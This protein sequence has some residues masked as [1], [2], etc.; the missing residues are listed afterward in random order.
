MG[1]IEKNDGKDHGTVFVG[2][3]KKFIDKLRDNI[4]K[5][6]IIAV[7]AVYIFQGFFS[8]SKRDTTVL[9]ILGSIGLSI[10]IGVVIST[11]MNSMGIK[12]GRRSELFEASMK[13]YGEAKS[14]STK[15][16]DKLQAWCEYKN[17]IDLEAKKKDIVL[18]AGLSWKGFKFGYYDE[19]PER[20]SEEQKK[21]LERA[22]SAKIEKLYSSDLLSDSN[23]DKSLFG[24][25]F[26]RFGKSEKD[27]SLI[28]NTSD[29]VYKV[30][31]GIVCGLY[32]LKPIFS[33]QILA[34]MIWNTL[35]ILLWLA[36]GSMKYANAKYFMEYEYRQSH[37][38]Q[39]TE[40]INE[41]FITMENR[42]E[43]IEQF[44]D[45]AEIDKYILEFINEK[46]RVK[47]N[48]EQPA[49]TAGSGDDGNAESEHI[50][51]TEPAV[52]NDG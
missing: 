52:E 16:F 17:S 48:A 29:M 22:K 42:P 19:H 13:A 15:Y 32:M 6:L 38:I 14:K 20:L 37:V 39:K 27:Y 35:Q 36:I 23:K 24:K 26:G 34:N 28:V 9:E 11:S 5:L 2:K 31:I 41:F 45:E 40:C 50:S 1:G 4:Q 47:K 49:D 43:V 30:A 3:K 10:I 21:Q 46:E 18:T 51:D 33:E 7:S 44:D 12:D 8:L 25:P